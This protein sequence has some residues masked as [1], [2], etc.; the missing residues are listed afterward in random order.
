VYEVDF[1]GGGEADPGEGP[2]W[3]NDNYQLN[4]DAIVRPVTKTV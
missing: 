2:G 1:P 3:G 4:Q